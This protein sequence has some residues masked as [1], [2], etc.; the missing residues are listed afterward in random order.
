METTIRSYSVK[1]KAAVLNLMEL[2][3]PKYF[4]VSEKPDF[5]NYL[6]HELELY[7]V[8]ELHHQII[9]CGGINFESN[10]TIGI[11]SWDIIHPEFHGKKLGTQLLHHRLAILNDLKHIEIVIVRTSQHTDQFYQKNGFQLVEIVPNYWAEG[12]DLYYMEHRNQRT[13]AASK[14]Q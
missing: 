1:D 4:A 12:F 7:F 9:G 10:Q 3:T 2:S 6:E 13:N 11:I 5:E 8:I 14:E